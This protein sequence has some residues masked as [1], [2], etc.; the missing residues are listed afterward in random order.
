ADLLLRLGAP[1]GLELA[2]R[3]DRVDP[4]SQILV[5]HV[6]CSSSSLDR[7]PDYATCTVVALPLR[8]QGR[9]IAY[10]GF[11]M[12]GHP[13]APSPSFPW[14]RGGV[15]PGLPDGR[16]LQKFFEKIQAIYRGKCA[17]ITGQLLATT[18]E[19]PPAQ[20]QRKNRAQKQRKQAETRG[21]C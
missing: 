18:R 8:L 14:P 21:A 19:K 12:P 4:V 5:A 16:G 3:R 20:K 7:S 1:D 11:R 2:R 17:G 10:G 13:G 15:E 9:A 6:S